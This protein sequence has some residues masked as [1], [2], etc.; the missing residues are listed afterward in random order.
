MSFGK[1]LVGSLGREPSVWIGNKLG[2]MQRTIEAGKTETPRAWII[3]SDNVDPNAVER[4]MDVL[5]TG[6][7]EV[8]VS[9]SEVSADGR[10]YPAGSIV[11]RRD[12]PYG[13]YV[14]DLFEAQDYPE[15]AP[16]YDV[17][18]WTLP[19]IM[20]VRQI[21]ASEAPLGEL[22]IAETPELAVAGFGGP[23]VEGDG[24][25]A[26][27]SDSWTKLV[28]GLRDGNNYAL[29]PDAI[30]NG[31]TKAAA[32]DRLASL[33]RIGIYSPYSGN[34]D[35]G[36]TR[37]VFDHFEIPFVSVRNEMLR[38]GNIADVLDVLVIPSLSGGQLERGRSDGTV[39]SELTGG[40]GVEGTQAIEQFV[41]RGGRLITIGSSSGW[42]IDTFALPL[43]NVTRGEESG[44]FS[45]PGSVLRA[46]PTE[47]WLAMGLPASLPIFFSRSSAYREMT[48]KEREEAGVE[49][50]ANVQPLL[51][52]ASKNVLLSG[53]IR[54]PEVIEDQIAWAHAKHG[55]GDI[56]VFGFRPQYRSWT[57]GSFQMLFRAVFF[58]G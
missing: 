2:A 49:E 3:P 17:A 41:A 57:H 11:V 27:N 16:P 1:S 42:A 30:V 43:V 22:A 46:T 18:G 40:I 21:A 15:G 8:H 25:S 36:W 51:R 5:I 9:Q 28:E 39:P 38:A 13:R 26:L 55:K 50:N 32:M 37:W 6:G 34:M 23:S 33:P 31:N 44:D 58:G 54:D 24:W 52:Y 4:L 12:Q 10:T 56:H 14:K 53:W 19:A 47:R 35:E 20:G 45:C 7:V 29:T 48:E